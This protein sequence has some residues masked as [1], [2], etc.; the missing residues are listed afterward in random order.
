MEMMVP[1]PARVLM[2]PTKTP[3]TISAIISSQDSIGKFQAVKV[4]NDFEKRRFLR[5]G[6]SY[7]KTIYYEKGKLNW[8]LISVI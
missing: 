1:P 8:N 6:T 3:E 5:V 2:K 7:L 4:G